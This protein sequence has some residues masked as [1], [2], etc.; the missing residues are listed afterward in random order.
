MKHPI[1]SVDTLSIS[2]LQEKKWNEVIHSISF[3]VFPNEILGIVGES[4]S[5]K[6]VSSLAIMGLLPKNN[7]YF[8]TGSIHYNNQNIS[9]YSEKEFQKIRGKKISMIFQEPMSSLNPSITCGEQV[10]E[11]LGTHT[12]L[13]KKEIKT[14]V[15]RL[16]NQVRLP[17]PSTIYNKYP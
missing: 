16:F 8:N 2:F 15:L 12:N 5:G 4:G 11:I 6:S 7:T 10:S 14:E 3:Q 1:L 17:E 13:S 9:N